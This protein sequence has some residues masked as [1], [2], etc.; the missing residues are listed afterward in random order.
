MAVFAHDIKG[1]GF[2]DQDIEDVDIVQFAVADM[3]ECRNIAT[4]IQECVEFDC[5]FGLT[6]VR[7]RKDG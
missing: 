5:G 1:T 3:N 2:W 6:E 4:Q 7:P